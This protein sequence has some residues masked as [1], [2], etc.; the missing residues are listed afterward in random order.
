MCQQPFFCKK[1][2]SVWKLLLMMTVLSWTSCEEADTLY[3]T[4][5]RAFFRFTPVTSAF[6]LQSALNNPGE[7]CT[8]TFSNNYY[9]FRSWDGKYS[10]DATKTAI[11]AYGKPIVEGL[12]GF[13][14][15]TSNLISTTGV[16]EVL[17]YGLVCPNC[18]PITPQLIYNGKRTQAKCNRCGR[19]YDLDNGG[20][21]ID[22]PSGT[23]SNHKLYRLRLSY[24]NNTLII[25]N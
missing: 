11:D 8:I 21:M 6:P 2:K 5:H 12:N 10:Y 14:V 16:N 17:C 25:N 22:N 24:G 4:T 3:D 18:N 20:I 1:M 13:L 7:W 9:H 19:V 15:G 23:T